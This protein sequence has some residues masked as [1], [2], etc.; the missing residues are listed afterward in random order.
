MNVMILAAGRGERMRP[1]S[2]RV[3]KPLLEV[4]GRALVEHQLLALARAGFKRAVINVHHLGE[5][6]IERL[7]DGGRYGIEI[8]YSR[9]AALL[10]TAGG[11]RNALPLL[12]DAPFAVTNADIFSDYD[13]ARL[14][15][16]PADTLGHL[17]MVDNPPW[18]AEGDFGMG[19]DGML[20]LEGDRKLTYA[21]ISV[22]APAFFGGDDVGPQS[23]RALWDAAIA[24]GLLT[25]EHFRGG[26]WN[27]GTP[28]QL[29]DLRSMLE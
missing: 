1:L 22:H 11:I 20:T 16:L 7:G 17:V 6:I 26:W 8:V 28:D 27:I 4:G 21:C 10:G 24:R 23:M 25:G 19:A 14:Q 12:G 9:E 29:A 15:R 18:H 13:F 2:D 3:P 5:Q